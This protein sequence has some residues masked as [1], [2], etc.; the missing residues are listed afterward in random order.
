M[1]ENVV[2]FYVQKDENKIIVHLEAD[3][4]RFKQNIMPLF[5]VIFHMKDI[6]K[7]P[8]VTEPTPTEPSEEK[9]KQP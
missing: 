7:I 4:E 1:I 8:P 9:P 5:D 3:K 6:V 2:S